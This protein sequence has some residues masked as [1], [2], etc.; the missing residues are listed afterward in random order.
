MSEDAAV[1]RHQDRVDRV[2]LIATFV[3]AIATVL[4]AWSAFQA[5]KWSGV[6][7]NSYAAAGAARTESTKASTLAGQ[8][9]II[10]VGLFQEW[11]SAVAV[12]DD[13]RQYIVDDVYQPPLD[14][15]EG[16]V[17]NLFPDRLKV[18]FDAWLATEPLRTEGAPSSPFEMDEYVV[19]SRD[20]AEELEARA[21]GLSGTARQ[22]NQRSDNYVLL[23]VLFASSLFF[24]GVGSKLNTLQAKYIALGLSLVAVVVGVYYL[25][26]FPIEI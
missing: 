3:L 12:A 22:A 6:Q 23:T 19:E 4:T 8:Q 16:F 20:Q 1:D 25:V 18:A 10:D 13:P 9:V 11:V 17:H 5:T 2:E 15:E 21:D 14:T 24:A 7:A 26:V